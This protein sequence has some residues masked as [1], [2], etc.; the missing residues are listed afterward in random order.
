MNFSTETIPKSKAE[1]VMGRFQDA[2][3]ASAAA[4]RSFLSLCSLV[5]LHLTGRVSREELLHTAKMMDC[6]MTSHDLEALV[7]LLPNH[8]LIEDK[9]DY[10]ILQTV[11]QNFVPRQS[12]PYD[13][14]PH[15]PVN[16]SMNATGALPAYATPRGG[17]THLSLQ[18]PY[19]GLVGNG[20]DISTPLGTRLQSPYAMYDDP[21][22]TTLRQGMDL[23]GTPGPYGTS[24][25][26][27]GASSGAYERILRLIVERVKNAVDEKMRVW[28]PTY[29]LR[30][31]LEYFDN[32]R[33]GAI[34]TKAFQQVM[35]EV[36]VTLNP[37]DLQTLYGLYGRPE[38]NHIHY[39]GFLRAVDANTSINNPSG[40]PAH[41]Q[42]S[43]L[44]R[45]AAQPLPPP[46]LALTLGNNR[47][48]SVAPYLHPR[49]LQRLRDLKSD[50]NDVKEYFAA[51]DADR[52]GMVSPK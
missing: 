12:K 26:Q 42:N 39:D 48:S 15:F 22:S 33:S 14:E 49:T 35:Q 3:N 1:V 31:H 43:T 10:R 50:G 7:E 4:G 51:H 52:S 2:I 20:G 40:L 8:A 19:G 24:R 30:E 6:P 34:P 11:A 47:S 21:L 44:R 5:D 28:G 13:I 23:N 17:T 29:T 38:D 16:A 37:S 41:M 18:H 32:S 45:S 36:G 25:G 9:V 27:V 46:P